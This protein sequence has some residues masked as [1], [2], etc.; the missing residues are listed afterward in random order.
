MKN[1]IDFSDPRAYL[2]LAIV[3]LLAIGGGLLVVRRGWVRLFFRGP[4][5]EM[6]ERPPQAMSP[7]IQPM[8]EDLI[9]RRLAREHQAQVEQHEAW[10]AE[11]RALEGR[12]AQLEASLRE[13][14]RQ[15][16]RA[17]ADLDRLAKELHT[18]QGVVEEFF[19]RV[20]DSGR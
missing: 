5:A 16:E 20:G 1:T 2:A 7:Q 11:R 18:T 3:L 6:P 19:D 13:S 15:T 14:Q 17:R 4:V 9:E 8:L 10:N 12:V